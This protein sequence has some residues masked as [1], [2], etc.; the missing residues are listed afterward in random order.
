VNVTVHSIVS[1][2]KRLLCWPG[3]YAVLAIFFCV[4]VG[5]A[6]EEAM[7]SRDLNVLRTSTAQRLEFY[8]MS[9]EATLNRNESLPKLIALEEKLSELLVRHQD[10]GKQRAANDYLHKVK[11]RSDIA[12]TYL[13]DAAGLT[14]A[15]SNAGQPGSFVGNSYSFRPYFREAMQGGLGRFYGIGTTT[16]EPGYFLAAPI[17]KNG[18]G[19]GAVAVKVSLDSFESALFKGGDTVLLVDASGVIFLTS[20]SAWKYRTLTQLD[21]ETMVQLRTSRQ[22]HNRTLR[23]LETTLRIQQGGSVSA[24]ALPKDKQRDFLVQSRKVGHLGW[25]MILLADIRQEQRSA[26]LAGIAAGFATAFLLSV[27]SYFHLYAKRYKERRQAEATLRQTHQKL[28]QRITERTRDLVAANLSLEEKVEALKTTENILHETRDNAVQAGKLAVLG[29]MSAGISHEINQPLTALHTFTDNAVNL[30]DLGRLQNVRENLGLIRQMADRMGHIIAEIKTFA[31]KSPAERQ[32]MHIAGALNQALMLVES[33]RRQIDAVID[34]QPF[35]HEL[36]VWAD[37]VRLE[38]VLVN[39]LRNALDAVADLPERRIAVTVLR[40]VPEVHLTLRDSGPGI[41]DEALPRLF[42]PFYTT[43]SAGQGLGLGL[44]ISRMI[45]TELG[46]RLDVRNPED[47][48]AE[49][50]VVLEEA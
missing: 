14:L 30:L 43:K 46:G 10:A 28:E 12:S 40:N 17:I 5:W 19:V 15:S 44:A 16:G 21:Q 48:G 4:L 41:A 34:I 38:Q 7:L 23:P 11:E 9:L 1:L 42:E 3:L 45:I 18:Y 36:Q 6:V 37:P 27:A 32:K 33:Q 26:L 35:P 49:F 13:M 24:V 31:R 39:L 22:Y 20:V 47:G 25:T 8:S 2:P 50:T 29:Q